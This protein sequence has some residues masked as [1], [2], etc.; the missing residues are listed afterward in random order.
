[1]SGDKKWTRR[2]AIGFI[3][4]GAGLFATETAGFT[5]ING[6]RDVN[7]NTTKDPNASVG[8]SPLDVNG[9]VS[10]SPGERIDLFEVTNNFETD[11]G[12]EMSID[13]VGI[14]S[15]GSGITSNDITDIWLPNPIPKGETEGVSG[16]LSSTE[17]AAGEV[18]FEIRVSQDDVSTTLDRTILVEIKEQ[19]GQ[20]NETET[21]GSV[22]KT[23]TGAGGGDGAAKSGVRFQLIRTEDATGSVT[24]THI[25]VN[26]AETSGNRSASSVR[27]SENDAGGEFIEIEDGDNPGIKQTFIDREG[28]DPNNISISSIE[29]PISLDDP[30]TFEGQDQPVVVLRRFRRSDNN[31]ALNLTNTSVTVLLRFADGSELQ[32]GPKKL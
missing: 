3:G 4:A 8:F 19:A 20:F 6:V 2:A 14:K 23:G 12:G 22:S 32:L 28:K 10:G 9:V 16:K 7:L 15:T 31:K 11:S 29:N 27:S 25:G 5:R 13:S 17:G 26:T 24:L 18:G 21:S 1:M 30:A